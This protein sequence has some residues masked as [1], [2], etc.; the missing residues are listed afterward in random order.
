MTDYLFDLFQC[1]NQKNNCS[2]LN[3]MLSDLYNFLFP[4]QPSGER[5]QEV[6]PTAPTTAAATATAAAIAEAPRG[7]DGVVQQQLGGLDDVLL[8]RD[9]VRINET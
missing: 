6:N 3:E 2:I 5:G 1:K 7:H 8:Q 9:E 4:E